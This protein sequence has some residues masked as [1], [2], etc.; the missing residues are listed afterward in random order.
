M[1]KPKQM[2]NTPT[3]QQNHINCPFTKK[4]NEIKTFHQICLA[5]IKARNLETAFEKA[6]KIRHLLETNLNDINTLIEVLR[7]NIIKAELLQDDEPKLFD[8]KELETKELWS[9]RS[10]DE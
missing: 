8:E 6:C 1:S 5:N 2:K 3:Q 7:A 10:K 9:E 4:L